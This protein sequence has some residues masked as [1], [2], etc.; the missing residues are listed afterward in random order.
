MLFFKK[1]K[2]H[3]YSSRFVKIDGKTYINSLFFNVD[4]GITMPHACE[5]GIIDF[6]KKVAND[7][8]PFTEIKL[9]KLPMDHA[10]IEIA[11][12]TPEEFNMLIGLIEDLDSNYTTNLEQIYPQFYRECKRNNFDIEPTF[13]ALLNWGRFEV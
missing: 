9:V 2:Q 4:L 13:N 6:I 3:K 1:H 12:L 10:T 5:W 11:L 7:F 8:L